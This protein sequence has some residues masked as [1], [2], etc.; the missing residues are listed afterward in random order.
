MSQTP[1]Q[2]FRAVIAR[3]EGQYQADP[4]DVG[5]VI[6]LPGGAVFDGP[7]ER[8]SSAAAQRGAWVVGT[9]RGVTPAAWAACAGRAAADITPAE[10]RAISLDM[11]AA[12]YEAAY[13]RG[14]GFDRLP[15]GPA[16]DV[17]ADIGWGSGP[18]RGIKILQACCGTAADGAIGAETLAAYGAWLKALGHERAVEALRRAR[19]A[20]YE[21]CVRAV[22]GN[23]RFLAGWQAR[24]DWQSVY[25]PQWWAPWQPLPTIS[26]ITEPPPKPAAAVPAPAALHPADETGLARPWYAA[27]G[28]VLGEA[29]LDGFAAAAADLVAA[30]PGFAPAVA[31]G[32]QA[33]ATA[34]AAAAAKA[35]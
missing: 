16:V 30:L 35:G 24:A 5:N 23:A 14:P 21:S 13:Y 9:M 4:N 34:S 7:A 17:A 20:W 18:A 29:A 28:A 12:I 33:A 27:L 31:A 1:R 25:S 6:H 22:P 32:R 26:S 19:R 3:W 11:A 2:A 10:M 15:W 8:R